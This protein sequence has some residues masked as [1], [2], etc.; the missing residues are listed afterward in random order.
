METCS[1]CGRTIREVNRMIRSPY[2]DVYICNFCSAIV[3]Q[4]FTGQINHSSAR[5]SREYL[6]QLY[7]PVK[8]GRGGSLTGKLFLT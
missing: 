7:A 4:V 5:D 2:D 8:S 3:N 1:F 6:R